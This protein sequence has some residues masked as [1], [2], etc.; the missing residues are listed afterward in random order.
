MDSYSDER[1]RGI[2]VDVGLKHF[3]TDRTR[4]TLLDAPGHQDFVP[5]MIAGVSQADFGVLIVDAGTN[6]FDAGL[7]GQTKEH[8]LLARGFGITRLVVV[9]NKMDTVGWSKNRFEEVSQQLAAFLTASGFQR[10]K[11]SFIPCA[12]LTGDNL[13]RAPPKDTASWYTGR[14]VLEELES[15]EAT[16]RETQKPLRLAITN[17]FKGSVMNPVSIS[18]RIESGSFQVGDRL[19]AMPSR[20][21]FLVKGIEADGEPVGWAV[22]GQIVDIHLADIEMD[23]L[24]YGD[25]V[26]FP[27][28]R[29]WTVK[30]FKAR[31][32]AFE[33]VFPMFVQVH[34]GRLD[35]QA[36]ITS[37]EARL[38]KYS[39]EVLKTKPQIVQVGQ[40]ARVEVELDSELP[41][42]KGTRVVL[43]N[44]GVTIA[45]ALIE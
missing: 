13:V 1:E 7:R 18:G 6:N 10:S 37:I 26:C 24:R 22:A 20:K 42:E 45:C 35:V 25:I 16:K 36:R 5:E 21:K 39:G 15:C 31:I 44:N 40:V 14:T 17:I 32:L 12:G 34:R 41:L 19:V 4:F 11:L 3:E 43:R 29:V 2:T 38:H 33:P 9:V 23:D 8:A 27:K 28:D 30:S